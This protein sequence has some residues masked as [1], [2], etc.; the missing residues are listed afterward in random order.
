MR[1]FGPTLW[2]R[3]ALLL[4]MCRRIVVGVLDPSE[5]LSRQ[6]CLFVRLLDKRAS[7]LAGWGFAMRD[8]AIT[9]KEIGKRNKESTEKD[10]KSSNWG[11]GAVWNELCC[12]IAAIYR[13]DKKIVANSDKFGHMCKD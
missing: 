5:L 2:S 3:C 9:C 7:Y 6:V 11:S 1:V 12:W 10:E 13:E 8:R 4:P